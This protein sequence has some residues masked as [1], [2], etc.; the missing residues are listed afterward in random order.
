MDCAYGG[1]A[2][3][4]W[5]R[6]VT[7]PNERRVVVPLCA[8]H[9]VDVIFRNPKGRILDLWLIEDAPTD[10]SSAPAP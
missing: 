6:A 4:W 5:L 7:L 3:A 2:A 1:H 8:P 10:G 9:V